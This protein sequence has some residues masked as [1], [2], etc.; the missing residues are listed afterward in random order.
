[1]VLEVAHRVSGALIAAFAIAVAE[2]HVLA[3]HALEQV[4]RGFD[5][6]AGVT[7]ERCAGR[8]GDVGLGVDG[9]RQVVVDRR[10]EMGLQLLD[11]FLGHLLQVV[12]FAHQ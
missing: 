6:A 3:G 4:Q 2:R 5:V 11:Q 10:I 7:V 12:H 1:M 9:I 8:H